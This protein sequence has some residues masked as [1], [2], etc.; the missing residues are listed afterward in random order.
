MVPLGVPGGTTAS[1]NLGTLGQWLWRVKARQVFLLTSQGQGRWV[2]GCGSHMAG[3]SP[4]VD[5][6]AHMGHIPPLGSKDLSW[7]KTAFR[8]PGSGS[9][10]Q[11][12]HPL[13]A[14]PAPDTLE[15]ILL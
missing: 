1:R 14:G 15:G 9:G 5:T 13:A 8:F 2:E 11:V 4:W 12:G 6:S 7:V 3:C 10:A